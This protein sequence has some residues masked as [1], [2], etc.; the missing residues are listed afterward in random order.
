MLIRPHILYPL[1]LVAVIL[2]AIAVYSVSYYEPD[3]SPSVILQSDDGIMRLTI[4]E[5]EDRATIKPIGLH[6]PWSEQ[7]YTYG[8]VE[9]YD[10]LDVFG[11]LPGA[12][13]DGVVT[14]TNIQG[15]TATFSFDEIRQRNTFYL[16]LSLEGQI[17][18]TGFSQSPYAGGPLRV[19]IRESGDESS[20]GPDYLLWCVYKIDVIVED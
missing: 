5:M 14:L 11:I 13:E 16:A 19:V 1:L 15:K 10:L 2:G 7:D 12:S 4:E 8:C 3:Q 6:D 17:L 20:Y 18:E 9:I